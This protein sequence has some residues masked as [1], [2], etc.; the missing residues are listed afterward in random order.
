MDSKPQ[1]RYRRTK[2]DIAEDI[3]KAAIDQILKNGFSGSLVTEIIKKARIE[4][5]VFYNRYKDLDEFFSELVK[6]CDYWLINIANDAAKYE[7]TKKQYIALLKGLIDSL[8]EKSVML[9][10]LRWEVAEINDTTRRTATI[11]EMFTTPLTENYRKLFA[12]SGVDFVAISAIIIGGIYYL[13]LHREVATF[14]G[15]DVA[16]EEGCNRISKA[17]ETLTCI[18]FSYIEPRDTKEDIAQRMRDKGLDENTIKE[19]LGW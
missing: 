6:T 5:P 4:P 9:E 16:T 3:R 12:H 17:V 2:A 11:R 14:C 19:C 15:I 13:S 1:K 10:L 8:K 18:L 7:S